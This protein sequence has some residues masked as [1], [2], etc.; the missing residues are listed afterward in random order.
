MTI[1]NL[2]NSEQNNLIERLAIQVNGIVQG[3]GFRPFVYNLAK[4]YQLKGFVKNTSEGVKIEV[5][6]QAQQLADFLYNLEHSAPPLA[7]I[8]EL[9]SH[10]VPVQ[11]E[12]DFEI[13][14]SPLGMKHTTLISPDTCVCDDCL[15]EMFDPD[16]RRFHYPFINCTNCGPRYTIIDGIPYDRPLTSMR[17][18]KQCPKCQSEYDNPQDRRFHAQPNACQVCGPHVW[19]ES[20]HNLGLN[21]ETI[22]E[23]AAIEKGIEVLSQGQILAVKGLGGFHLVVDATNDNAVQRLRQRKNREAKPLAIMV[24]DIDTAKL[25]VEMSPEEEELLL[26]SQRPIVLLR[27]RVNDVIAGAVAPGNSRLG[28]MLPYTPLHFLLLSRLQKRLS[29]QKETESMPAVLVM[30]SANLSEEPIVLDNDEAG[31]RLK[32]IADHFL[33]HNRDILIRVDDSVTVHLHKQRRFFRRSRG[34]VPRPVFLKSSGIPVLAVGGELKNTLCL[35]K[36]NQAFVSQHIGDLE[37]LE[38]FNFFKETAAHLQRILETKPELIV[39]DL[40]PQYLSTQWAK[41]QSD[42]PIIGVQHHHAHLASC[43]AEWKLDQPVIGLIMDGTGYGLDKTIWGGEVLIGD[44]KNYQRYAYF[45]PHP[46]P[47]GDAAIKAPWRTAV[48]YLYK[49][50]AADLPDLPFMKDQPVKQIIQ[51]VSGG[52]NSPLTSS[53]GRLFDAVAAM[54]G[55]KTSVK[56]EAQAAIEFMQAVENLNEKPFDFDLSARNDQQLMLISPIIKSIVKAVQEGESIAI[57]SSRFHRT[58]IELF[59]TIALKAS[60]Y[61]GVKDVIISGGVFQNEVLFSGLIPELEKLGLKVYTHVQLPCNDGGISL[62]Q[63]MIGRMTI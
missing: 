8:I 34:Y 2:K 55:G 5:E 31:N 22:T 26:S 59:K 11:N 44:Y 17:N 7:E 20:G 58:M 52:L 4:D 53:C 41:E 25:L 30:T 48:S 62:G 28:I 37:N 56:Y 36:T 24:L 39:H 14:A 16:N 40:H 45:E 6:G 57:I 19:F 10:N 23:S 1:E 46:L 15:R 32:D 29:A 61:S 63:A 49:T 35:V 21:E 43:M 50:F 12:K 3:V 51:M 13:Q 27:E 33:F 60:R 9:D 42:I 18:F 54:S 38:A 47:G